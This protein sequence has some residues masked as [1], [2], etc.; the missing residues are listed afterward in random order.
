M[1]ALELSLAN[2]K[3]CDN[4]VQFFVGIGRQEE[5]VHVDQ[6]VEVPQ[7]AG[8]WESVERLLHAAAEGTVAA[9]LG[10]VLGVFFQEDTSS[11]RKS[12]VGELGSMESEASSGL[13][14]GLLAT[15]RALNLSKVPSARRPRGRS[16]GSLRQLDPD[17]S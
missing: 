10:S 13:Q 1:A 5:V 17:I 4:S 3:G 12:T 8:L 7:L 14:M 6:D 15:N 9:K 11:L 16:L 2:S